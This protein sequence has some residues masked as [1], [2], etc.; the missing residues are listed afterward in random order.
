M[1]KKQ[2]QFVI[3]QHVYRIEKLLKQVISELHV[4]HFDIPVYA[5][6][7]AV[8][9]NY[10]KKYNKLPT[11]SIYELELKKALSDGS[12]GIFIRDTEYQFL[13]ISY[14][15]L[16]STKEE[17]LNLD[18]ARNLI[19]EYI[20][21]ATAVKFSSDLD[22]YGQNASSLSKAIVSLNDKVNKA[23]SIFI[24]EDHF[25]DVLSTE[26]T[27]L[28]TV[29]KRVTTGIPTCDN[30]FTGGTAI[31]E[32]G[33]LTAPQGVG[34]TNFLINMAH[35][36]A[37]MG[38]RVLFFT[39]E[40]PI[41]KIR[42][43]LCA[44]AAGILADYT[45]QP[46]DKWPDLELKKLALLKQGAYPYISNIKIIEHNKEKLRQ[47]KLE[48]YIEQWKERYADDNCDLVCVDW[49]DYVEPNRFVKD[50]WM[51]YKRINE[52]FG[53]ISRRLN[54]A[55]WT[56]CQVRREAEKKVVLHKSDT[57]RGYY[58]NDPLDLAC[59]LTVH[60]DYRA[61]DEDSTKLK[62]PEQMYRKMVLSIMKDREGDT[63]VL[64]PFQAPTLRFFDTQAD[65]NAYNSNLVSKIN[66]EY[67]EKYNL[68]NYLEICGL[69]R[70]NTFSALQRAKSM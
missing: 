49:I 11:D 12:T 47:N 38:H 22:I 16:I 54:V 41:E 17:E 24:D 50:D 27:L 29:V 10:Y 14:A 70:R 25:Q 61:A 57:A 52:E 68:T 43:R 69:S 31:G 63:P 15:K 34:K 65:Y 60:P 9:T 59:G 42:K 23:S 56:A 33:M 39:L 44:M 6:M 8:L 46:L 30:V 4:A 21:L 55:L 36:A 62:N 28:N 3:L 1:H 53:F 58:S 35:A 37:L 5:F 66:G 18:Y 51:V 67:M 7:Y 48:A 32:V 26:T 19:V 2:M 45:K 20:T 40:L 64:C 13:A